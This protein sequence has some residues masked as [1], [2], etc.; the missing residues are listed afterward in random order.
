MSGVAIGH[1][2]R[3]RAEHLGVVDAIAG[4]AAG[5]IARAQ[6]R[7]ADAA[8]DRGIGI[9]QRVPAPSCSASR[10]RLQVREALRAPR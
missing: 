7:R 5:G 3:H 2:R 6:Q 1:E 9:H 8:G 4:V 10:L